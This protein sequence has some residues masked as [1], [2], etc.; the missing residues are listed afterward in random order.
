VNYHGKIFESGQ[1]N[2]A[3]IFPG[4]GMGAIAFGVKR[5]TDDMFFAAAQTLAGLVLESDLRRGSVYPPLTSIREVS[6]HIAAAIGKIGYEK[7]LATVPRPANLLEF[8]KAAQYQPV[9][10]SYV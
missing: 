5:I 10:R 4:V 3:Y 6:A 7:G 2:N 8:V 1:G 9:Y